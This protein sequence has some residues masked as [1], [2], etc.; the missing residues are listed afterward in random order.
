MAS[1]KVRVMLL[2]T[3]TPVAPSVG[4]KLDTVGAVVSGAVE[5][6]VG[7]VMF[8]APDTLPEFGTNAAPNVVVANAA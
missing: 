1:L 4:L 6:P 2:S 7:M 8:V 3:A 5:I